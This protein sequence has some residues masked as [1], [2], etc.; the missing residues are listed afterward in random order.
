LEQGFGHSV[1]ID[2]YGESFPDE[3]NRVALDPTEKD[4]F[5]LPIPQI[6]VRRSDN[7]TKMAVH[8][9]ETLTGILGA[10]G[11]V[12]TRTLRDGT[13]LGTH[14]MGTCRMGNDAKTSVCNPFGRT[15]DI[16]NLFIADG[17]VFPTATPA[18]PT[19]TIQA[20]ATRTALHIDTL[21]SHRD[22]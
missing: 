1:D 16:D 6:T 4:T 15:H 21:F 8:M 9:K 14:L 5:G 18:N 11:A 10:V 17:S 13:L 2:S 22:L 12:E 7:S 20:L 3:N 19:L